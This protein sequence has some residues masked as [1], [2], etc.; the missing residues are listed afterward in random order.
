MQRANGKIGGR[1]HQPTNDHK[2]SSPPRPLPSD[3]YLTCATTTT[4]QQIACVKCVG[5]YPTIADPQEQHHLHTV[6]LHTEGVLY[7]WS[8]HSGPGGHSSSTACLIPFDTILRQKTQVRCQSC[9]GTNS[10]G[11]DRRDR[12]RHSDFIVARENGECEGSH[13][14]LLQ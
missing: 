9:L 1:D 10:S 2:S 7:R 5:L 3:N 12:S 6:L 8:A 13:G 11:S 4:C 14:R